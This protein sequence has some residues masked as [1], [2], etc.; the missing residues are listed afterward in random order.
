MSSNNQAEP[1]LE[2]KR[3]FAHCEEDEFIRHLIVQLLNVYFGAL[4]QLWLELTV[5]QNLLLSFKVRLV[6]I[7]IFLKTF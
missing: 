5:N 2:K 1:T 3:K 7:Q 6:G 4:C